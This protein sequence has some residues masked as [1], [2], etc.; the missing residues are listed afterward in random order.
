MDKRTGIEWEQNRAE[1]KW[2]GKEK[3]NS[4][5][6]KG[7]FE[8]GREEGVGTSRRKEGSRETKKKRKKE[9]ETR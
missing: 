6:L 9:D 1:R 3:E 5:K 8:D 4:G 2:F 7:A